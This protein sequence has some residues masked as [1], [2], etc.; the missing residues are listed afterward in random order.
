MHLRLWPM[1]T[2]RVQ[3]ETPKAMRY[4]GW[5]IAAVL[6]WSGAAHANTRVIVTI[7]APANA[8]AADIDAIQ[9]RLM[10][11]MAAKGAKRV[12]RIGQRPQSV[13]VASKAGLL[14][15]RAHRDVLAV[16][17]DTVDRPF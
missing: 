2:G 13:W 10:A 1:P 3:N 8:T 17:E 9:T 11:A 16:Q 5:I 7:R 4:F 12:K 15:L 6:G 14:A